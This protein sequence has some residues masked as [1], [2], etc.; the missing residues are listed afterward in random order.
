MDTF[1]IRDANGAGALEFFERTPSDSHA[2]IER[3]KVRLT[4]P[5]LSAVT[6]VYADDEDRHP[7]PLFAKMSAHWRGWEGAF[8]WE[9]PEGELSL[10]CEQDRAG[11]VSLRVGLRSGPGEADWA[12][13]T[14][15]MAEA[16]QLEEIAR[17]AALFFGRPS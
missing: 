12:L 11:H 8:D 4:G 6:R 14:T 13:E 7:A 2:P 9:S 15:V 10:R 1:A 16:G 3:F 17:Q 5:D